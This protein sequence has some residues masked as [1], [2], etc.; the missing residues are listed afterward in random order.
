MALA[1]NGDSVVFVDVRTQ[2]NRNK[3]SF[4]RD[5]ESIFKNEGSGKYLTL[6]GTNKRRTQSVPFCSVKI[7]SAD[8]RR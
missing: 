5:E 6:S 8:Y 4:W 3:N 2:P 1:T 7:F